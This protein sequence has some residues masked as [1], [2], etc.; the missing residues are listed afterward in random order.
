M[1]VGLI[2]LIQPERPLNWVVTAIDHEYLTNG[3]SFG[4][5]Y[6]LDYVPANC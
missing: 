1:L 4:A 6:L 3:A 5:G 2:Q